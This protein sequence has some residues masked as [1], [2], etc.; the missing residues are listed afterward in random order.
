MFRTRRFG[1]DCSEKALRFE[2][3]DRNI[4]SMAEANHNSDEKPFD[5]REA[6][7]EELHSRQ[8]RNSR[9][10]LRS[11]GRDLEVSVTALSDVLSGKRAFSKRNAEKIAHKLGWSPL[12]KLQFFESLKGKTFDF[13]QV[14]ESLLIQDDQFQ[15]LT[16]WF[17]LAILNLANVEEHSASPEWLAH[18]LGLPQ[19]Q[20]EE[21]LDR[22]QRLGHLEIRSEKLVRKTPPFRTDCTNPSLFRNKYHRQT[23]RLAEHALDFVAREDR[24]ISS[25]TLAINPGNLEAAKDLISKFERKLV[26]I[27]EKGPKKDVYT[28][29]VQLFPTNLNREQKN[30]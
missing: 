9:Y 28:L 26:S 22:L 10:S 2:Q 7:I 29:A 18:R 24:N 15:F 23:L 14:S 16:D 27:L 8:A 1:T 5:Y 13:A 6:L 30:D 19:K 17:Y 3:M 25:V 20:V 12:K 4:C 21:A 11:F